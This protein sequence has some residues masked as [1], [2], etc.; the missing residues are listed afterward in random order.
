MIDAF[1]AVGG[2]GTTALGATD[3]LA[4]F[5]VGTLVLRGILFPFD[6]NIFI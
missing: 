4:V 6:K 5:M 2:L 1:N 3:K